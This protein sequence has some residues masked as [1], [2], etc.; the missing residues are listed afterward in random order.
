MLVDRASAAS[1]LP[2]SEVFIHLQRATFTYDEKGM[3]E[4]IVD[5]SQI[6]K[7]H[8]VYLGRD[9]ISRARSDQI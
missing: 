8:V 1:V 6:T 2:S 7:K 4:K 9:T 5:F 3:P